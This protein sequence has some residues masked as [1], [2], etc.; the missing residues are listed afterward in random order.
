MQKMT[1]REKNDSLFLTVF[2]QAIAKEFA[3]FSIFIE[4]I[5]NF[6]FRIKLANELA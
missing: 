5:H 1:Q 2:A 6:F 4:S 3:K